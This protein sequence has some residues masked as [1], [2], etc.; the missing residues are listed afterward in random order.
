M[1]CEQFRA[2]LVGG[3]VGQP[4]GTLTA[5]A[6]VVAGVVILAGRRPAAVRPRWTYGLLVVAV[7]VGSVVQHGPHPP[8]QAYAHDL[9][10]AAVLGFVAADAAADLTGRRAPVWC[11]LVPTAALAPVIMAGPLAS[12][13]AQAALAAVAIGLGLLRARARPRLRPTLLVALAVLAAGALIG[14]LGERTGWCQPDS[15]LQGHAVWHLL[16]AV[17]L[18]RLAPAIGHR[19]TRTLSGAL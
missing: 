12:T 11:W 1:A 4:A 3:L 2:G 15:L 7:G 16:A 18:W 19:V 13:L 9:P 8:W 5:L 14:T 17:A 6:L 10:L